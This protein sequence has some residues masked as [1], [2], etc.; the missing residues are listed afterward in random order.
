MYISKS[1]L[2]KKIIAVTHNT[3]VGSGRAQNRGI[4]A[5]NMYPR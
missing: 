4:S 1:N 5:D 3:K 2:L